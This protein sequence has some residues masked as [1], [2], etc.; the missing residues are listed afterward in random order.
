MLSMRLN[1]Y[2]Y[3]VLGLLSAVCLLAAGQ[4]RPD[5]AGDRGGSAAR[6]RAAADD[7]RMMVRWWW[8]GPR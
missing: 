6:L 2:R 3:G 5:R 8:Y 7:A 4:W 1:V